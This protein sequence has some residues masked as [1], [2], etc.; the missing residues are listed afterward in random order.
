VKTLAQPTHEAPLEDAMRSN[1]W[2]LAYLPAIAGTLCTLS[3][4][5]QSL[6]DSRDFTLQNDTPWDIASVFF[7]H[8]QSSEW[9]RMRMRYTIG[10]GSSTKVSF[11]RTGY[12]QMQVKLRLSNGDSPEW[13]RG[14]NLC[15][16]S[17]LVVTYNAASGIYNIR[18]E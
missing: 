2:W 5:R 7:S 14:F 16:A 9:T 4:S 18:S 11:D 17:V 10:S 1:R 15:S 13:V 12:C 8:S 3:W 6:A